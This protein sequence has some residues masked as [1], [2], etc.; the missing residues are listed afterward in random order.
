MK[1]VMTTPSVP[2][3]IHYNDGTVATVS[4]VAEWP[5]AERRG[6]FRVY[7]PIVKVN[8]LDSTVLFLL[9]FN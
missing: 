3:R 8:F 2:Y 5:S 7:E 6:G 4:S 9:L 1:V